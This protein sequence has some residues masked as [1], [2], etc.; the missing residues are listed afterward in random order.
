MS[1]HTTADAVK[2]LGSET[3]S[4]DLSTAC[5]QIGVS[6][7]LTSFGD[8]KKDLPRMHN[9]IASNVMLLTCCVNCAIAFQQFALW[10]PTLIL[11]VSSWWRL[12]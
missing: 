3:K 7:E 12:V 10:S 1:H 6:F 11:I 5:Q 2:F 4:P 9:S 8:V